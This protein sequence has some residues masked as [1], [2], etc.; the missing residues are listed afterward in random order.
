MSLKIEPLFPKSQNLTK[1]VTNCNHIG[2]LNSQTTLSDRCERVVD[3]CPNC[4][5][6]SLI[7]SLSSRH[8]LT[9]H[10]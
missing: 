2:C 1:P 5:T 9:R 6:H 4:Q 3:R 7:Y 8:L 10:F